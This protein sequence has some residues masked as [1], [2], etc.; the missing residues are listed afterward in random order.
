MEKNQIDVLIDRYGF[1]M[2]E[3]H[4]S[5]VLLGNELVYKIK[6]PVD[7]G[8]L[9]YTTIEKRLKFCQ[10]EIELNKRLAEEIY[11]GVSMITDKNGDIS[12]DGDGEVI[13]YAVK[14]KRMP[15]GR[16]MDVLLDENRI[17]SKHIDVLARK[18]A[19]FHKN[20]STND[21]IASFGSLKTNKLNTDE[22]FEQTKGGIG[23]FITQFQYDSVK[24]YTDRFYAQNGDVFQKRIEEGKVR[25]C[26]GDMYSKNICIVDEDHIYIYDCIEFNERFRYSD[27][28][29]DVA[30]MLMDLENKNRWDLSGLF[31]KSYLGYS[32]DN[33][34]M[35]VL[36]FYKLY[37]AYVRGKIAFF[38]DNPDEA[39]RYFD[40]A[41]GYLP[42]EYKPKVFIF[43][44]LSGS[45]KTTL[46]L[47]LSKRYGFMVL[48]S[49]I[50]RK[51][52]AGMD[53]NDKDLADFGSGIYSVK[54]TER[55]YAKMIDD[56]YQLA[57][58]GKG[59]IL[60]ATFLKKSQRE[61]VFSRFLRL[62]IKPIVV[63]ID[64]DDKTAKEH[65]KKREKG[66]SVSDGRYEIYLKQK[67]LLEK[68]DDAIILDGKA[69]IEDNLK[70]LGGILR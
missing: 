8:F 56:A 46:A 69:A 60:D 38:Q 4:I 55:V 66:K 10:K 28:A 25:D 30:F 62:G 45:G 15:Q 67:E 12:I 6:K 68:P 70:V 52:L 65:F 35:E 20:A 59:V 43:S 39:N 47:E 53:V 57:R 61:A 2:V 48:S 50:I 22:N 26:H 21:Y 3:T 16:M 36:D 33:G 5:W 9:D 63:F 29:S 44:G 40:L 18:I 1:E 23:T 54:M 7:F 34:M 17:N 49:D 11:L 14:M 31:L 37:R 42:E 32:S 51:R 13:D 24:D 64:I 41:F 27:V 58:L 19:D